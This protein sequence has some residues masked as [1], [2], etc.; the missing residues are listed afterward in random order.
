MPI[1][2]LFAKIVAQIFFAVNNSDIFLLFI[3]GYCCV[4]ARLCYDRRMENAYPNLVV[5]TDERLKNIVY[6]VVRELES[7]G[8]TCP[9]RVLVKPSSAYS[10]Y[11]WCKSNRFKSGET[12][13]PKLPFDF[14]IGIS[15]HIV[16][17]KDVKDVV[18]H[19]LLHAVA[20][21]GGQWQRPHQL[22][23]KQ[24]AKYVNSV[25]G[26]NVQTTGKNIQVDGAPKRRRQRRVFFR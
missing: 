8:I 4:F 22:Q 23:W 6:T 1:T 15:T 12:V 5:K 11:G 17:D 14:V 13:N 19:E 10:R 24:M 25:L 9:S 26:Y 21:S 18:A 20:M 16:N 3:V 7:V 2:P